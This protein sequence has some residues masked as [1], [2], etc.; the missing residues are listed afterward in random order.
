MR[1][2]VATVL[3]S[4]ALRPSRCKRVNRMARA[5]AS[6][7]RAV[8]TAVR[9]LDWRRKEVDARL[10]A[11][12]RRIMGRSDEWFPRE[13]INRIDATWS[14]R[15]DEQ[16]RVL[17]EGAPVEPPANVAE[18]VGRVEGDSTC[19][20]PLLPA[21]GEGASASVRDRYRLLDDLRA[22]STSKRTRVCRR[23]RISSEVQISA[24]DGRIRIVGTA[25]CGNI[26]GCPVCAS[27]VYAKRAIE[28]D[29]CVERWIGYGDE[30]IGPPTAWAGMLTTTIRHGLGSDL[31][32]TRKGISAAWRRVFQGSAGQA[33]KRRLKLKHYVRGNEQ[34]YGGKHGWHPHTHSVLLCDAEPSTEVLAEFAQRWADCVARELGES[35]RPD[36]RRRST[37]KPGV[38]YLSPG[39]ECHALTQ[40]RDGR[41]LAKMGLEV[42]GGIDTKEASSGNRTYW[43]VAQDAATGDIESIRVWQAAQKALF[44]TKQL[45]WSVGTKT[46]FDLL[47]LDDEQI[48]AQ[49]EDGE[50]PLSDSPPSNPELNGLQLVVSADRW[51]ESCRRDRF[52]VSRLHAATSEAVTSGD[53]SALLALVGRSSFVSVSGSV[54]TA[55]LVATE[56]VEPNTVSCSSVIPSTVNLNARVVA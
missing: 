8:A 45:T 28:I 13:T 55:P 12:R 40:S 24:T 43:Q 51:D 33:L 36:V 47:D 18:C 1:S 5:D 27:K 11:A 56:T 25:C 49:D 4:A 23:M 16:V 38:N 32:E 20:D 3:A 44:G 30:R 6:R 54:V 42:T 39:V 46:K 2:A 35:H 53:W 7:D 41:Y 34:T 22:L 15:I 31:R 26:H 37:E 10:L 21:S 17:R 50:L 9:D 52:F 14:K 19:G 48:V 29:H